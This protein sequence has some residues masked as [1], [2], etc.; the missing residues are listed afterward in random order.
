MPFSTQSYDAHSHLIVPSISVPAPGNDIIHP[1][2]ALHV[3][4][5][6]YLSFVFTTDANVAN[7]YLTVILHDGATALVAWSS[8]FAQAASQ[9]FLYTF[10]NGGSLLTAA[11]ANPPYKYIPCGSNIRV[12]FVQSI[13]T[14]TTGIQVGDT[15]TA[16]RC[17]ISRWIMPSQW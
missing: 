5:L 2:S 11:A 13:Q 17:A 8:H 16:I 14:V 1:L 7:R 6:E 3:Y 10:G 4:R 9:S 12:P 15:F